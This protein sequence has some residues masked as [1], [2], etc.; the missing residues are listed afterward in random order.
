MCLPV[1]KNHRQQ[2]NDREPVYLVDLLDTMAHTATEWDR[3]R[4]LI[5]RLYF[6]EKKPLSKV[7]EILAAE[8]NFH[9][10]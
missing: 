10:T 8:H 5:T 7:Q 3:K 4:S 2:L 6:E 9:A 1:V